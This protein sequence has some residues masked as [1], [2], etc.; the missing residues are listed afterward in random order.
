MAISQNDL[1]KF[2]S[3]FEEL[4]I[5]Q[6]DTEED[7]RTWLRTH[8]EVKQET[9]ED[10]EE[11][12]QEDDEDKE[13]KTVVEHHYK[14]KISN[15]GGTTKDCISFDVWKYEVQCYLQDKAVKKAELLDAVRRSV[16]GDA[17]KAVMRLG[18][19]AELDD[20]LQKLDGLYGQVASEGTLL[21]LFYSTKQN[22]DEDVTAWSCRLEDMIQKVQEKGLIDKRTMKEMLRSKLWTGL[23][24]EKLKQ[25]TRHKFDTVKD[26]NDLVIAIRS[27]EQ[28]FR[29]S[30]GGKKKAMHQEIKKTSDTQEMFNKISERLDRM[31]Q[32][33]KQIKQDASAKK[34]ENTATGRSYR[35]RGG[36]RGYRGGWQEPRQKEDG[37]RKE[38][39]AGNATKDKDV[40][41]YRCGEMGH[42]ALGCRVRVDH[43]KHLNEDLPVQGSGH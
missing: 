15:F 14:P 37:A 19:K 8:K 41:C 29:G 18:P 26:Y 1:E 42:I 4:G 31:E 36:K 23:Y 17:A 3:L 11:E 33:I 20:I 2:N 32:D 6:M 21:T 13:V 34:E 5:E 16:K 40:V 25:A 24:D 38:M 39:A 35:G 12:E 28:E 43:L 7:L 9:E 27:V 30:T 22:D 10:E